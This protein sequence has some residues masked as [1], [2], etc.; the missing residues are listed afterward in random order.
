LYEKGKLRATTRVSWNQPEINVSSKKLVEFPVTKEEF[1]AYFM[2]DVSHI[3][4]V[5]VHE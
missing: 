1:D 4:T 3:F 2:E 5:K